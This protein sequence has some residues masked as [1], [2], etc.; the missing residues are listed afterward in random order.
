MI[1]R[2]INKKVIEI[3]EDD[4]KQNAVYRPWV[5]TA[6]TPATK[7]SNTAA[8]TLEESEHERAK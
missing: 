6:A 7:T 4:Y 8:A 2:P 3:L 5:D 1:K